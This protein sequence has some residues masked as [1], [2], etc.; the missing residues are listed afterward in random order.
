MVETKPHITSG[1]GGLGGG[2]GA[3]ADADEPGESIFNLIGVPKPHGMGAPSTP[4]PPKTSASASQLPEEH[5]IR[6]RVITVRFGSRIRSVRAR[7]K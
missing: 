3:E 7:S 6:L 4:G 1:G 5:W 2:G